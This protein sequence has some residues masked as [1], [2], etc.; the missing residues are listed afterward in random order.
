MEKKIAIKLSIGVLISIVFLEFLF[1]EAEL[2]CCAPHIGI[3]FHLFGGF[4]VGLLVYYI[5]QKSLLKLEWYLIMIF[6][7]GM[8]CIA[9]VGWEGFEWVLGRLTGSL[10][11]V[12][13]DNTM[14]DLFVGIAGGTIA[15]PV[16]LIRN[17]YVLKALAINIQPQNF[18]VPQRMSA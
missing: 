16:V 15:C 14:E 18:Q 17:I 12:S 2:F 3:F 10:Y 7:I 1:I 9:A 5:F 11:Q 13:L 4:F 6:I 8:V